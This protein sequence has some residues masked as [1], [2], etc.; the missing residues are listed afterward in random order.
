MIAYAQYHAYSKLMNEGMY[1]KFT[2]GLKSGYTSARD[3]TAVQYDK[4]AKIA[5]ESFW[6]CRKI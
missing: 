5:G 2:Q 6:S 3:E 4:Y 1:D